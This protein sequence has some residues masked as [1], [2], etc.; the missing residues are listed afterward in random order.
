MASIG[1][2]LAA[3]AGGC[4][5]YLAGLSIE[6]WVT[7]PKPHSRAWAFLIGGMMIVAN[8]IFVDLA[9][10]LGVPIPGGV[11]VVVLQI[12][13]FLLFL[14]LC[15]GLQEVLA[16]LSVAFVG[17]NIGFMAVQLVGVRLAFASPD[18]T[19]EA[20][21]WW[22]GCSFV[23]LSRLAL[24]GMRQGRRQKAIVRGGGLVDHVR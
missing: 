23:L 1:L 12:Q 3:A 17:I 10:H 18:I 16:A 13:A 21:L 24:Q 20:C 9:F 7:W 15:V 22:L 5:A 8:V 19:F 2:I 6:R 14:V 4:C 11:L